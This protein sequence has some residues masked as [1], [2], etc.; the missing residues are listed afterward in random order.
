MSKVTI[1]LNDD[2]VEELLSIVRDMSV[3]LAQQTE[4]LSI[5][6]DEQAERR[7]AH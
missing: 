3:S 4:M 1:H 7:D 5:L 6:I 2:E